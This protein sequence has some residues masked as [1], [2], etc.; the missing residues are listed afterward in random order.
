[1]HLLLAP[2]KPSLDFLGTITRYEQIRAEPLNGR[3]G[4][5]VIGT[6]QPPSNGSQAVL[7]LW[8]D[9]KTSL[10]G[11]MVIDQTKAVQPNAA[12]RG[13]KVKKYLQRFRFNELRVNEPIADAKFALTN[14]PNLD[15]VDVLRMPT[16]E[17]LQR[18]LAGRPAPEFTGTDLEGKELR[19]AD[20]KGRVVLLDFW[21]LRCGPCIASMP[22]LQR[23]ADKF[24]DKPVSIIGI[25][26]DD[27]SA[28]DRITATLKERKIKFRQIVKIRPDLSR[29]YF[30]KGIPCTALIDS[31]GTV[32]DV[33]TGMSDE[34]ELT[35]RITKLLKGENLYVKK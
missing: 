18:R 14:E 17:E 26:L 3:A 31:K 23:V 6:V 21:S 9:D 25:N 27:A 2:G 35:E 7:E 12:A 24:A 34:R 10:I 28:A 20:L 13:I 33:H 11:E 16:E 8:F 1:M 4:K 30:V 22:T 5:R 19:S 32:Q 15:K 29:K